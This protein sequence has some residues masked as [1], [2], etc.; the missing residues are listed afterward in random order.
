MDGPFDIINCIS[1]VSEKLF[2]RGHWFKQ[3]NE[4]SENNMFDRFAMDKK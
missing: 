3:G 4:L 2:R 1:E